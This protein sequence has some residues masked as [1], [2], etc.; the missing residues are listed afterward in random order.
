MSFMPSGSKMRVRKNRSSGMPE[1]ISIDA[2]ERLEA[3]AGAV[4]PSRPW[5]EFERGAAEA[6]DV[7]RQRLAVLARHL[8][9]V[10]V[11]HRP[12]AEPGDVRQQ[13]LDR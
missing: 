13:I 3:G 6:R 1:A 2:A 12:A 10:A 5:L 7:L 11:A 4:R 8:V 9:D